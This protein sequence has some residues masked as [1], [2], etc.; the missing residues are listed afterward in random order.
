MLTRVAP[1][2]DDTTIAL[3]SLSAF[4]RSLGHCVRVSHENALWFVSV[5]RFIGVGA[6][7]V[8]A[9][10]RCLDMAQLTA[11]F[12]CKQADA[13]VRK[14]DHVVLTSDPTSIPAWLSARAA[15]AQ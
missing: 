13:N 2:T 3:E 15:G 12:H 7:V 4:A 10:V 8:D 9:V 1:V 11:A 5:D 14:R 6:S